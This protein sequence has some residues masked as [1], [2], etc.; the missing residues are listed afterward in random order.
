MLNKVEVYF[1]L[2][3]RKSRG[4]YSRIDM[5]ALCS[6][7]T[8]AFY[9]PLFYHFGVWFLHNVW[10][11]HIVQGFPDG[12]DSKESAAMQE[13]QVGF[14]GWEDPLQGGMTIHSN[15]LAWRIPGTEEPGGL[16]SMGLQR[17]GQDWVT[18]TFTF[19]FH[20]LRWLLELQPS[21][22]SCIPDS[23]RRKEKGI[24][25]RAVSFL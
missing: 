5:V 15:I 22:W 2:I 18:D 8:Q 12:W 20:C 4:M 11:Y 13:I 1:S 14:L 17:V 6:S 3:L 16:Q 24:Y 23:K 9:I 21:F 19:T 7:D 25:S 10:D